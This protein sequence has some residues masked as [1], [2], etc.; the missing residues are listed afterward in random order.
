VRDLGAPLED[1]LHVRR[2]IEAGEIPGPRPFVSGP[3]IQHRPYFESETFVR[4]GVDGP[5]DGP[6]IEG[7]ILADYPALERRG[8]PQPSGGRSRE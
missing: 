3:F 4:W 5:E 2:R 8:S 7:L 1:I 6:T